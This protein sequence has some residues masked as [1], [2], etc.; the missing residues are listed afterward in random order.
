MIASVRGPCQAPIAAAP[1]RKRRACGT[2]SARL[3]RPRLIM[4][5]RL[6]LDA[7]RTTESSGGGR[8][9]PGPD[10]VV[11]DSVS[12]RRPRVRR[13]A[14]AGPG[15]GGHSVTPLETELV[16]PPGR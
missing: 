13:T 7:V 14:P 8:L 15:R 4:T 5:I 9:G 3:G 6:T 2:G 10:V 1:P 16:I 11:G 12:S